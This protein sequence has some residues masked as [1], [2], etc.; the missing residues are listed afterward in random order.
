MIILDLS[1]VMLSNIMMQLGNHTNAEIE[2]GMVRHMVLNSIR[3]HKT[4]FGAEYGE[5][6]IACDNKNYWRRQLFPYYKANRKKNQEASEVNWKAIFECLNKIREELKVVFPY[7][8]IDV[9]CAEADDIIG[10]LC[11][12]FGD[13]QKILILSGDKDFIQLQRYINVRQY[14]PVRK[15]NI[16]HND[17][18]KFL[19]E[20][21]LKGDAGDGIPNILSNDNCLVVGERQRPLTQK[22]ID[23]FVELA[24]ANKQDHPAFRNFKRNEQLIDLTKIP[25]N[26]AA[27]ILESYYEQEGKKPNKLMDYFIANKLRNLMENVGEFV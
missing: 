3:S 2:E 13:Y 8:V 9:E 5:L 18:D 4:K 22:K 26:I 25:S 14:D 16:T 20:H 19:F 17:P 27:Q 6:V 24:I 7:R 15:K 21:I 23:A 1:Q 10:T 12:E 11:R